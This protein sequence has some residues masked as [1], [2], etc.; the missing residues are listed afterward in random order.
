MY[1]YFYKSGFWNFV[2]KCMLLLKYKLRLKIENIDINI[3]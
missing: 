3:L 1:F 2:I